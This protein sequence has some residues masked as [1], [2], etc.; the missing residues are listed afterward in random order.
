[1][2]AV[3]S[4]ENNKTH[5]LAMEVHLADLFRSLVALAVGF[6]IGYA[7]GVLHDLAPK[8]NEKR[9]QTGELNNGWA[10]MPGSMRRVAHLL[11]S[12]ILV[13]IFCP[14]LF[15]DGS[16]WCVSAGVVFAYGWFLLRRLSGRRAE[17]Q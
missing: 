17:N 10:G 8:L 13:Q 14:L 3:R 1:L 6:L 4:K 11:L 15:E 7:F 5:T 12:L 2:R 16:Q 9:Q